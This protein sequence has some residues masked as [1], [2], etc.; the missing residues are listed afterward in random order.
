MRCRSDKGQAI[1]ELA[2]F[3]AIILM[4]FGILLSYM[5]RF[6]DQQYAQ[7]EVFRRSLEKGCTYLG[8]DSKGQGAS[9]QY[10]LLEDRHHANLSGGFDKGNTETVSASANVFWAVPA[11]N[12]PDSASLI[13]FKINE[14]EYSRNYRDFVPQAH[15]K[16]WSFR[17]E[18]MATA[19]DSTFNETFT[20][21][22]TPAGI[23]TVRDSSLFEKKTIQIPYT[24][25]KND[26]D[27]NDENDVVVKTGEFWEKYAGVGDDGKLVQYLYRDTDDQY[28]YSSKVP[29]DSKVERT[30][31]WTTLFSE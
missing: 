18:E 2:I 16:D 12:N 17:T 7:M 26:K 19:S 21:Q 27:D 6:N 10:T 31:T 8:K 28:K 25:R 20:K 29:A 15:D 13:I 11:V 1:M 5:Q 23:K 30:R 14:D 3:G 9:V 24:I 22:E 4:V